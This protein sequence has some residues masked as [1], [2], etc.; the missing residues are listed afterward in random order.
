MRIEQSYPSPV[1]GISTLAP[2]TRP[3][4]Y[5]SRQVNFRSD[6]V[7]KL[8]RRP[9]SLYRSLIAEVTDPLNTE[10]HSYYRGGHEFGFVV[11][12]ATGLIYC[13][14][15]DVVLNTVDLGEYTGDNIGLFT[16]GH[17]TYV[18]NRDKI[19]EISPETDS[20]SVRKITHINVT[21]ALNYSETV[22]VN[23]IRQGVD[24]PVVDSVS[25]TIPD[26]GTTSPDYDA[27]DRAR[28]TKQVALELAAL[29]NGSAGAPPS[30][31]VPNPDYDPTADDYDKYCVHALKVLV[32]GGYPPNNNYDPT[33]SI[34]KPFRDQVA[35]IEGIGAMAL[36]ST[37][38]IWDEEFDEQ[39]WIQV[40]IEAGQGDR[41]TVAINQVVESTDGLP[42]YA[43]VGTR[44][45]VRPDPTTD[46]GIYYL[47]AERIADNPSG[48]ML[49]EV[50]WSEDRNPNEPYA[51]DNTTMPHKIVFEDD[52]FTLVQVNYAQR[53][54]GDDNSTPFPEFV[55]KSIQ[56]IG[57]FQKRLVVVA[58]N[59]VYMTETEKLGNWFKKS[60]IKL[61][62][63][64]TLSVT[65]SELGTDVILHLV[66]H[67]RDL[68]CI[69]SNSQ[70]KISGSSAITPETVSMPLTTK[71]ECQVSVA[72]VAIGNSV[73]FPI[74]YGDSTGIQEYTGEKD[75]SQDFAAP[76]TN[77]IIGYLTGKARLLVSSPNLEM[78]AMTTTTSAAN[79]IFIY[80]QY[81]EATGKRSQAAWSEW[82]LSI[83]ETVVDMRFRKNELVVLVAKGN[84]LIVK[85]LPMYTRVTT[86]ALD[87]FLDDML[88]LDTDG[89]SV[90]VPSTYNTDSCVVV[91]G[92]GTKNE[93]WKVNY[94]RVGDTLVFEENI[95]EGTVYVGKTFTSEY[96]PTRPFKYNED[97]TVITT[98]R[99]RVGKWILSLVETHELTMVKNSDYA[100]KTE[101][102]FESRFV[103]QYRL[104][105]ISAYTGD[106]KFSFNEDAELATAT[107][108]T[109]SYLGCTIA[110]VSWEGQYF[111]SKGRM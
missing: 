98:D 99:V 12:K 93:L 42:L 103:N 9:P 33:R 89:A 2:R 17:D 104:G 105:T 67:N 55:G 32:N 65:T 23:I 25:Y 24:G 27:A 101:V 68:L 79:T 75:T 88:L 35:G 60:A 51:F 28:A 84:N 7:N 107:F 83:D 111:Q 50:V 92:S 59:A 22:Q 81:T 16:I 110:G 62:V 4:G 11:D 36:G 53:K 19:V 63:T 76:I 54:A 95:G 78:L 90:D 70:F 26:L 102:V 37:V 13:T 30:Q 96:E 74:D 1:H 109:D 64:D 69:T 100:D 3:Q 10:Y 85:A 41:T 72:P 38:A 49:E 6:P 15:D 91:R 106:W 8:T 29:I 58:E 43:V 34:C 52:V 46:K 82:V 87:V 44:I 61:L 57:Y 40:E 86:S 14:K 80:E 48:M 108:K 97:G 66:P 71:Y 45:T 21:S 5:A 18:L 94:V 77:H 20:A 47:Q 39:N 56:S 73:Y 31:V